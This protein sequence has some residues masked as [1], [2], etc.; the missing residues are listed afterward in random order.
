M[1]Q[2]TGIFI[3][4]YVFHACSARYIW[5]DQIGEE[6]KVNMHQIK[7]LIPKA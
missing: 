3:S 1:I 2:W 6:G 7:E 4:D 5:P